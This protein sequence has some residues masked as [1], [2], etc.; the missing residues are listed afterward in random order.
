MQVDESRVYNPGKTPFLIPEEVCVTYKE[1]L[2]LF[3]LQRNVR[4][5]MFSSQEGTLWLPV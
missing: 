1:F 2:W 3:P 5:S 4:T